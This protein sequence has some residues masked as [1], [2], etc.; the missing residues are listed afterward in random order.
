L[1]TYVAL[2]NEADP[3]TDRYSYNGQVRGDR[4]REQI[5]VPAES[6]I[7]VRSGESPILF[8]KSSLRHTPLRGGKKEGE[9]RLA[10]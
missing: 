1:E 4:H 10:A 2:A 9:E 3:E 8:G 5:L 7:P 6:V